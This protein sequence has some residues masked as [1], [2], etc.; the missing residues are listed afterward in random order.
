MEKVVKT[1]KAITTHRFLSPCTRPSCVK[2][3]IWK[4]F[5]DLPLRY[6]PPEAGHLQN[7]HQ[8]PSKGPSLTFYSTAREHLSLSERGGES[9]PSGARSCCNPSLLLPSCRDLGH[10]HTCTQHSFQTVR[11]TIWTIVGHVRP[12]SLD[13]CDMGLAPH[14]QLTES[15]TSQA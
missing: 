7:W 1:E 9:T 3:P 12:S 15:P 8:L 2:S 5:M 10:V 14:W 11:T 6:L 4:C 13:Y